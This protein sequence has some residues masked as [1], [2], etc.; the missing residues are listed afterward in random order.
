MEMNQE[1]R[2]F[3]RHGVPALIYIPELTDLCIVPIDISGGGFKA[4]LDREPPVEGSGACTFHIFGEVF[5]GCRVRVAWKRPLD[6]SSSSLLAGFEIE[7]F[8][9][10]NRLQAAIEGLNRLMENG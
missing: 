4:V 7:K 1:N 6:A 10:E 2:K 5:E 8:D 3:A 9:D